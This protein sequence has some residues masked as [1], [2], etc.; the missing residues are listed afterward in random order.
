MTIKNNADETPIDFAP[1]LM[2]HYQQVYP[3][4]R[5]YK[6]LIADQQMKISVARD[7]YDL[8]EFDA[9]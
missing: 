7:K 8:S 1:M 2:F 9:E 6:P 5:D 3:L 4:I